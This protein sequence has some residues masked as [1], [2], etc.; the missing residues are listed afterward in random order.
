MYEKNAWKLFQYMYTCMYFHA[1]Q[2]LQKVFSLLGR[3]HWEV[4]GIL[5]T[6]PILVLSFMEGVICY[7]LKVQCAILLMDIVHFP[8]I[9]YFW[10]FKLP[11][12]RSFCPSIFL[13][14]PFGTQLL[15]LVGLLVPP[16]SQ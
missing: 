5:E 12:V 10:L 16:N 15:A 13:R 8:Y 2:K 3:V 6:S 4:L 1:I 11:H 9:F 14:L 7:I